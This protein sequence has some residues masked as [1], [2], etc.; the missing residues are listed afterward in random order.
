M[1]QENGRVSCHS[2][3]LAASERSMSSS[4]PSSSKTFVPLPTA[5]KLSTAAAS[6]GSGA[7]STATTTA[8]LHSKRRNV[9]SCSS[10]TTTSRIPPVRLEP[11]LEEEV[12]VSDTCVKPEMCYLPGTGVNHDPEDCLIFHIIFFLSVKS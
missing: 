8:S 12:S 2:T 4:T 7:T 6:K 10:S 11:L 5:R 1:G 3:P 9:T